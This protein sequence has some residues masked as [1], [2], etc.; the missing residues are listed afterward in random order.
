MAV[1]YYQLK[2]YAKCRVLLEDMFSNIEP[3]DEFLAFKLCF[4]LLDVYL[5]QKQAERASEVLAYL[6]KSFAALTTKPEEKQNGDAAA[7]GTAAASPAPGDKGANTDGWPNKRSTTRQPPTDITPEEVR[8]ALSLYK[9]K[10]ALMARSSKSSKREIKTTLNACAQNTTGLFLKCNLEWQR[11]NY[12]KAIKLLNNSCQAGTEREKNVPALYFN[13][14]GCIHHCMRRH[15]AAAFYFTRALQENEALY[16]RPPDK[17]GQPVPLAAFSCD[18]KC[19][20]EYN[21]GL[22]YLLAGRPDAAFPAFQSALELMHSQPRVWL[23]LGEVC[24]ASYMQ[25]QMQQQKAVGTPSVSPLVASLAHGPS[26]G[27]GPASG[28]SGRARYLVLP[29]DGPAAAGKG[30]T[31]GPPDGSAGAEGGASTG[32]PAAPAPTLSYGLKCLRNALV[33]CHMQLG[34]S[35][36]SAVSAADYAQLLSSS[37]NGTS[38]PS[39]E[40]TLQL[41]AVLRLSLLHLSWVSLTLGDFAPSLSWAY[42]LLSVDACPPGLKVYAHLYACDALCQLSRSEEALE[43]LSAA[44]ALNE[45]LTPVASCTGA[46]PPPA[47]DGEGLDCVRNPYSTVSAQPGSARATLYTNL[48]VVHILRSDTKQAAIYVQQ[49]LSHQPDLRQALL[50]CAWLELHAGRTDKAL[51][52]LKKHRPP[53]AAKA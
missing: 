26:P 1:L 43:Q 19:E 2:Q 8:S 42:Q 5:L 29:T 45:P 16:Q 41:H 48:A 47:A 25:Q 51:E 33:L 3:I 20:L 34:G 22:Q 32:A 6:E 39:D 9:A 4:L 28:G 12:R 27:G 35:G 49:A 7:D 31:A 14:M 44:L 23:R 36:L 50:C 24:V 17:A 21:R 46:E 30:E 11:Q 15:S 10:L 18:R 37:A 53:A 52:L 40:Q 13:N 38:S